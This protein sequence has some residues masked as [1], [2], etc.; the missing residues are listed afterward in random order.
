MCLCHG[1]KKRSKA[2][3]HDPTLYEHG[4]LSETQ[5]QGPTQIGGWQCR[6]GGQ[7]WKRE[8]VV[9]PREVQGGIFF[10]SMPGHVFY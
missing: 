9:E 5:I 6:R 3:S 2:W 10:E 1:W 7:R 8:E 4:G